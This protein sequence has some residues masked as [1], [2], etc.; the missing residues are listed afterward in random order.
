MPVDV[1]R[2]RLGRSLL[3]AFCALSLGIPG[4][5]AAAD[6]PALSIKNRN[7]AITVT[8]DGALKD[9]P[10]LAHNLYAEGRVWAAERNAEATKARRETP[11]AFRDGR[12]WSDTRDYALRSAIGPLVS[13]LRT[14]FMDTG[15]AHPNRSI[16]TILW[17]SVTRKRI[18]IRPFF[19][20]TADDGPTMTALAHLAALAVA[21]EKIGR[22][23]P[24]GTADK[25]PAGITPEQYIKDDQFIRDGIKPA[26]LQLGPVT[27]APSTEAGKSAGL[28]FHYQPYAVGPYVDGTFTVF[29]PR[30]AFQ[31]YLSPRG[32][33]LFGGERPAAD[34]KNDKD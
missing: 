32:R 19:A 17:D 9:V 23:I 10:G 14:D 18:S 22:G 28:T 11:D 16:D 34:A 5:P 15:G 29:V 33:A 6:T 2:P 30:T 24:P 3:V 1:T 26:L 27:L 7:A 31:Q 8:I 21:K 13:I 20:E 12:T 4:R 25:L